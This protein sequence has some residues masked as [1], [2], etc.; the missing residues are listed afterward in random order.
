LSALNKL[1][2]ARESG[3]VIVYTGTRRDAEEVAEFAREV[4]KIP[5]EFYHAGLPAPARTQIQEAFINGKVNLIAATNAFGMGIDRADVRHV[6]HYSLPGS[7]EAYYQEAGRAGRDG[8]PA[9]ATLLY[10]PHDR[11]LQEFFIQQNE[12]GRE[13]LRVIHAV[14][15]RGEAWLTLDDL[16]RTTSK[17]PVQLKVGLSVLERA[18]ALEHLGDE[19]YRML[20]RKGEW[21]P[22]EID[23]AVSHNQQHLFQRQAQLNSM[24]KYAETNDCR[25]KT[26]L[27]HFGDTGETESAICCDNCCENTGNRPDEVRSET[28]PNNSAALLDHAERAALVI[29]D[30]IRRQKI[31]IGRE[32]LAQILHGSKAQDILKFHHDQNTYYGKLSL[33]R[34]GDIENLIGQLLSLGYL[35]IIGGEYPVVSLTPRGENAI[36]KKESIAL[37]EPKSLDENEL[38]HAKARLDAGGTVEYT[39]RLVRSGL[40]PEQIAHERSLARG[41][42]YTHCE[43]LIATGKLSLGQVLPVAKQTQI[44]AVIKQVGSVQAITSI[45][46]LLPDEI[47]YGMI[48]CVIAARNLNSQPT[49][50]AA[51]QDDQIESFLNRPH[52]GPLIGPWH[53]GWSL[54]FHSRFSGSDW[55]RSTV[56]DLTY[57]LKYQGDLN[58][59]PV[60]VEQTLQ[61]IAAHPELA[62]VDVISPVPPS[63]PRATDPVLAFCAALSDKIKLPVQTKIVKTRQTRPQKELKTLAQKRANVENAFTLSAS[64][65]GQRILLVDDLFDS[66]ATLAEI[67]QLLIE[68][69]ATRV[70]VLTLTRTIHSDA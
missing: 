56:G 26:I 70:N 58:T 33:I 39:A 4:I 49:T 15:Q 47:D 19:G 48:R 60:L 36:R 50:Q 31:K 40:T 59:L 37:D 69:G 44:E 13:D 62:Q 63:Q 35:K 34:Q 52:P 5:A 22:L 30:C 20:F 51:A 6:I 12:L 46:M 66:G 8:L 28:H 1:L 3:A 14:I 23:D 42:I 64:A 10:D 61:V 54:G 21:H 41:T 17:H 9:R 57:R 25:R 27:N 53:C 18:G 45:K 7:L 55:L 2:S 32:K 68:H 11:A 43:R 38:R 29:L 24:V 67:T 65:Q 16:S